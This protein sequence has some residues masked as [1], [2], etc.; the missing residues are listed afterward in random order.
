MEKTSAD[1]MRTPEERA[2]NRAD[3]SETGH[4]HVFFNTGAESAEHRAR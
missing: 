2:Q 3:R 4:V 1:Q